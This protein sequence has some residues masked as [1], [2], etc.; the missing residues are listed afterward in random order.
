MEESTVLNQI[1]DTLNIFEQKVEQQ[2]KTIDN[3]F[4][5]INQRLDAIESRLDAVEL[6]LDEMDKRF[7]AMDEKIDQGFANINTRLGRQEIKNDS[8]RVELIETQETTNF[9]LKK[10]TQHEKR[11]LELATSSS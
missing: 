4:N 2:F 1:L 9:L 11:F 10:V 6:R 5:Q 7:D 8:M 3:R